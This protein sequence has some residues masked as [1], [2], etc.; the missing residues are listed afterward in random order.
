MASSRPPFAR[1]GI[2]TPPVEYNEIMEIIAQQ[3]GNTLIQNA[4]L[5]ALAN[6]AMADASIAAWY[7]KYTYNFWRPVTAIRDGASDGNP[8]TQAD[9]NWTPLGAAMDNGNPNGPYYTPAFPA[10]TSGHAAIGAAMFQ[11]VANFYGTNNISFNWTSDEYDGHTTDQYGF[12]RPVVTRH[13]D[14]LSEAMYENAQSRLYLGIH[15]PWDRDGGLTQGTEIGDYTFQN[16]L[17][18]VSG[19]VPK[20]VTLP[21]TPEQGSFATLMDA[22]RGIAFEVIE[23]AILRFKAAGSGVGAGAVI[24]FSWFVIGPGTGTT[25]SVGLGS[26]PLSAMPQLLAAYLAS[27]Q[28]G[29]ASAAS[30]S[31]APFAASAAGAGLEPV[32]LVDLCQSLGGGLGNS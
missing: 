27:L 21:L 31:A 17:L 23:T 4:R 29:Q 16:A 6:L 5:F 3:Q 19:K 24:P 2:G 14:T 9:P 12:V 30:Q 13:Y 18:P 10:D 22:V 7:T 32:W 20:V 26:G 28:P 1:P 8:N 15:W 25:S 11:V